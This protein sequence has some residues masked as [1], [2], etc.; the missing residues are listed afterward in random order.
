MRTF[1]LAATLLA[2]LA[3]ASA[4]QFTQFTWTL[5]NPQGVITILSADQMLF[6]GGSGGYPVGTT[7]KYMTVSPADAL[8][9]V[10]AAT[11]ATPKG[12]CG[13]SIG[14]WGTADDLHVFGDCSSEQLTFSVH[15]GDT[16]VFGYQVLV[17]L[18]PGDAVFGNFTYRP[19]WSKLGG[20]LAG[21]AGT[22]TLAGHGVP[23]AHEPVSLVVSQA[24]PSAPA[25]LVIGLELANAPFKGGV[26]VPTP[27]VLVSGLV[28]SPAGNLQIA[29]AWPAGLPAFFSCVMQLWI[30]DAGG[31][32]GY[33]ASNAVGVFAL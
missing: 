18:L 29:G 33:S 31:P 4:A 5:D 21:S 17:S 24:A 23:E 13:D 25:T 1:V 32:K 12:S 27:D 2:A 16:I 9:S 15:A 8:I 3:P 28:T 7:A 19:F 6:G 10:H 30:A 22:P 11:I 26:L 20:A 14:L